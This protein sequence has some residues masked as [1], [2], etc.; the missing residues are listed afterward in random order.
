MGS[1]SDCAGDGLAI[2]VSLV[3]ESDALGTQGR[4]EGSNAGSRANS[5]D[6]QTRVHANDSAKAGEIEQHA[7]G[8]NQRRVA[9]GCAEDP[10]TLPGPGGILNGADYGGLPVPGHD[11]SGFGADAP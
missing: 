6:S 1:R 8:G 9:V 4:A 7:F 10:H 2:D 5:G 3:D 11:G